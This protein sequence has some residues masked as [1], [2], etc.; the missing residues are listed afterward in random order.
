MLSKQSADES[1]RALVEEVKQEKRRLSMVANEGRS[2][3]EQ[4][5]Y[6][7]AQEA[8]EKYVCLL[9]LLLWYCVVVAALFSSI[10]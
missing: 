4:D 2:V 10:P 5:K 6:S 8:R 9:W 3:Q 1:K 7:R